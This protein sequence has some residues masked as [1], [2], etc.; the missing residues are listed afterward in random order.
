MKISFGNSYS[1]DQSYLNEIRKE[2]KQLNKNRA[3]LNNPFV[4]NK[5]LFNRAEDTGAASMIEQMM[6]E[7]TDNE[8]I[9]R[10]IARGESLT[11][12]EQEAAKKMDPITLR[13]AENANRQ[14]QELEKKLKAAKT[15]K[16]ARDLIVQAKA[17]ALQV[18]TGPYGDRLTGSLLME[19][20]NEA[21]RKYRAG[22][23]KDDN[24]KSKQE[25]TQ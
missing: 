6:K 9:L 22:E 18:A 19:G 16:E 11:P 10:K 8:V 25:I 17:N 14:R 2:F 12:A 4:N 15:E 24:G 5:G 1:S 3:Y 13:K 7:K 21:E 23:L 20:I